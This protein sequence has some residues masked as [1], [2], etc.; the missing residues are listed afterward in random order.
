MRTSA[1]VSTSAPTRTMRPPSITISMTPGFAD[2]G[3]SG[4]WSLTGKKRCAGAAPGISGAPGRAAP[5]STSPADASGLTLR[6]RRHRNSRLA[7]TPCRRATCDREAPATSTSA[8][9]ASFCSRLQL[10]RVLATTSKL[11][12]VISPDI[13]PSYLQFAISWRQ[14]ALSL[15][16]VQ[17][18]L[19]RMLTM[20]PNILKL[21]LLWTIP[22]S[23]LRR[24]DL[25]CFECRLRGGFCGLETRKRHCYGSCRSP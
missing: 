14:E 23:K 5:F 20:I 3:A 9:I 4:G 10:L 13:L 19:R 11:R 1:A 24:K 25:S 12:E 22:E 16:P 21:I 15:A 8:T 6:F 2:A 7:C 17:G 18:G